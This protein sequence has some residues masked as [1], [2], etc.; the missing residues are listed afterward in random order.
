MYDVGNGAALY[1]S[2]FTDVTAL[3]GSFSPTD[4]NVSFQNHP[5]LFAGDLLVTLKGTQAAAVV[6]TDFGGTSAPPMYGSQRFRRLRVDFY[7]DSLRDA[8]GNVITSHEGTINLLS[9]LFSTV[10]RHLHRRDSDTVQWGDLVTFA[11]YLMTEPVWT[12]TPDGDW[13]MQGSAVYGVDVSGWSDAV[14]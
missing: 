2:G 9:A 6:C 4:P 7:Q 1:L 13:G 3:L 14:S 8:S 5:Y 11:S 10:N 12:I